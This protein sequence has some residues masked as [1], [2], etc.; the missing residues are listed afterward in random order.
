MLS[1]A[2]V[3]LYVSKIASENSVM[4]GQPVTFT[5]EVGNIGSEDARDVVVT[6]FLT[7]S[8]FCICD[9]TVPPNSSYCYENGQITW[10]IPLVKA[11]D[12]PLEMEITIIP[13]Q[14]NSQII[15]SA[16]VAASKDD[17]DEDPNNNSTIPPVTVQV[18]ASADLSDLLV[19]KDSCPLETTRGNTVEYIITVINKGPSTANNVVVTDTLPD[20]VIPILPLPSG[21]TYNPAENTITC[22]IPYLD[23]DEVEKIRFL[24]A[25]TNVEG[26]LKN[27]VEVTSDTPDP[28]ETNNKADITTTVKPAADISIT[29][30]VSTDVA[31]PGQEFTYTLIVTN[32]GPS[33]ATNVT[34]VDTHLAA[35]S[36]TDINI[37]EPAGTGTTFIPPVPTSGDITFT[38]PSLAS[39]ASVNI[40]LQ[41]VAEAEGMVINSATYNA[42]NAEQFDPNP[43]NNSSSVCTFIARTAST[44]ISVVKTHTP[45][46]AGLCTPVLY[47]ITVTN[48][49]DISATG[50]TMTDQFPSTLEILSVNSTQG[51]CCICDENGC[52]HP[53]SQS[54][55]DKRKATCHRDECCSK[56]SSCPG[57]PIHKP[58]CQEDP[59]DNDDNLE[60]PCSRIK[61]IICQLG[62]LAPGANAVVQIFARPRMVGTITNTVIVTSN[63][64]DSDQSNNI[65]TDTLTVI[66]LCEQLNQLITIVNDMINNGEIENTY[67]QI[68]INILNKVTIDLCCGSTPGTE[69]CKDNCEAECDLVDFIS[70]V[71]L[72]IQKEFISLEQGCELIKSAKLIIEAVKCSCSCFKTN[73]IK[74]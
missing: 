3:D 1:M 60:V 66:P 69:C 54:N 44:N 10:T 14:A 26:E 34:V 15:N 32:N 42:N 31:Q 47:T 46:T 62:T 27:S 74:R 17:V 68:L 55:K 12:P 24:V 25:T 63:E 30:T 40:E 33:T 22:N 72:F 11:D 18:T 9:I 53:C 57:H 65:F 59:C 52:Q 35:V 49:S 5:V 8:D 56:H 20:G 45:E 51:R 21:C 71:K 73:C 70:K 13:R 39:G 4:V 7:G 2:Q 19:L 64:A 28:N 67:G 58:P 23:V 6:D 29:K 50:I 36:I 43:C 38:I 41:A 61:E 37:M 16:T 48:I